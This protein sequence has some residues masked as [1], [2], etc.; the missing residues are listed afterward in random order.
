MQHQPRQRR[1]HRQYSLGMMIAALGF[2]LSACGEQLDAQPED[3]GV[4]LETQEQALG[5]GLERILL[6]N[7]LRQ[8]L[9]S[10]GGTQ[11]FVLPYSTD[12]NSIPQDPLNP[13]NHFKVRLG[14]LLFHE[15]AMGVNPKRA[16][17]YQTYSCAACHFAGA[18]FQANMV[19]G[20]GEGGQGV[21][22]RTQ[23]PTYDE[24]ELDV[25]PIRSPSVMNTAY[26]KVML[27]NGQFGATGPNVGTEAQWTP[28]TPK[29]VNSLGFE[30]LESQAI[31]GQGV[32]RLSFV[33]SPM[34]QNPQY[35]ALFNL[36]FANLPASERIT[37]VNAGLAI[38]A[39]ERTILANKA[40]WQRWLRGQPNAMSVQELR[41][42]KLFF[43][44]ANCVACHTGPAL[45][46][47]SF[48]ALGFNDLSGPGVFGE[49][50]NNPDRL[51]R[52][53]FTGRPEDMHK[54]KTPQLYN[55]TDSPF[56]G[57][58]ASKR[59]V[60]EVIEYKNAAIAENAIVPATQL[61]AEFQPLGLT[62]G[63]MD[64]LTAF[65]EGALYDPSL[66]RYQ[67]NRLPS[68]LCTPVNDPLSRIE[69]GCDNAS[70]WGFPL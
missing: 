10:H 52:G 7:Q 45:N 8:Q 42:A 61:A 56:F 1:Q 57:H 63:E 53:G 62:S 11:A 59:S 19:Q 22:M 23:S 6:G 33:Q 21:S 70:D 48:Y 54:F 65:I 9:Q 31:A 14:E 12:L 29:A 18:G 36:A 41:G 24:L 43:G 46:S 15:T 44:K 68:G 25:Q 69:L 32:H 5:Q 67:P 51:G 17:G 49:A 58:G 2:T 13:L 66:D 4:E 40:P 37:D 16:E 39:Y 20:I 34:A 50:V 26:Q 55:L 35:R 30:G 38:G 47:M 28:G 60:R 27:W 3:A 64:D